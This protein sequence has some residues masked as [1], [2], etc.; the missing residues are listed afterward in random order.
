MKTKA[1]YI[2]PCTDPLVLQL[3]QTVAMSF[4]STDRTEVLNYDEYE[5][6]L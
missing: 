2:P 4:H 6:D 1:Y 5:E 3:E